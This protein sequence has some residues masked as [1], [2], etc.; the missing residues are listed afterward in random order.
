MFLSFKQYYIYFYKFFYL[1]IFLKNT[2]NVTTTT[3]PKNIK[4]AL[5]LGQ[6]NQLK[7]LTGLQSPRLH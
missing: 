1:H 4:D 5:P 3:R 7:A 2:N 6:F